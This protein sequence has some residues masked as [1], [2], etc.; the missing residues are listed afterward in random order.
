MSSDQ[1]IP[2]LRLGEFVA[3]MAL[4]IS[5]TALSIDTILPALPAIATE[6]GLA[7]ANDIQFMISAVFFGMAGGQIFYGPLSDSFGRKPALYLALLLY[8]LGTLICIAATDFSML[9]AGRFVQ[10]LGAAGPRI[11]TTALVRDQHKGAAMARIMSFVMAV[12]ILVPVVAPAIGQAVLLLANWRAIFWGFLVLAVVATAWFVIRQPETLTR[13][14]RIPFSIVRIAR[15]VRE[16]CTNRVSLGYTIATGF[17]LGA[18]IGYLM[19][20]QQ[21]LQQQYALGVRFPLY[22]AILSLGIGAASIANA[23]L[24]VRY[25][26]QFL[27][28]WALILLSALSILFFAIALGAAG[29]PPF[30][31]LIAY[32]LI[33]FF[34]FGIL[35]GN[36]NAMAME[37]LGHIAG[38]GASVVGSLTT[39]MSLLFGTL[40]GQ[41]YNG[42]VL[43]MVAGFALLGL[44]SLAVTRWAERG[45]LARR[46][47]AG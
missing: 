16:I 27:S 40:I 30:A 34:C 38:V 45:A 4:L 35:F 24:V 17:V 26:M 43:P 39:F 8:M 20:A 41:S 44:A 28:R 22:F 13:T 46:G 15:A 47:E 12:F 19:S 42:T 9:L 32:L 21:I 1:V 6:L 7:R 29:H 33:A 31:A 5:L 2:Q 36:F 10:G 18:F 14:N 3:M 23:R 37:P 11:V 25:G